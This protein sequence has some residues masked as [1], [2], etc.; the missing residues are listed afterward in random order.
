MIWPFNS[1]ES[2]QPDWDVWQH[3]D[4]VD[5]SPDYRHVDVDLYYRMGEKEKAQDV[6]RQLRPMH[7]TVGAADPSE[8]ELHRIRDALEGTD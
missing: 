5:L 6:A 3:V 7:V 8:V 1:P 2:D 4:D